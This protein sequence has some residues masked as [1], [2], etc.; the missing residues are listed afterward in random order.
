[1][2]EGEEDF[3]LP[4]KLIKPR[5]QVEMIRQMTTPEMGIKGR[6]TQ[7]LIPR[8]LSLPMRPSHKHVALVYKQIKKYRRP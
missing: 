8:V 3:P 7:T 6:H 2:L 4:C 5:K 1:M